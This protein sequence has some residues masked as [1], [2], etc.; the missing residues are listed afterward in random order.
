MVKR[1]Q[2]LKALQAERETDRAKTAELLAAQAQELEALRIERQAAAGAAVAERARL[3]AATERARLEAA[4]AVTAAEAARAERDALLYS[5][6]WRATRPLRRVGEAMSMPARRATRRVLRAAYWLA[7]LQFGRRMTEWRAARAGLPAPM[8]ATAEALPIAAVRLVDAEEIPQAD[9]DRWVREYDTLT[10]DDRAAIRAHI[11]RL[12]RKPLISVVM[13]AYETPEGCCAR[14]SPRYG[15]SSTRIGSCASSTTL[16]PRTP[17]RGYCGRP[18][19]RSL[20][21][22][23]GG[24]RA[25]ATSRPP[26]TRHSSW[27]GASSSPCLTTTTC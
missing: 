27:P 15:R 3:E 21:S 8:P 14:R 10:D 18:R 20:G 6:T 16:R 4:A 17:S 24:G 19:R 5:T 25:T 7:T 12:G 23:G 26:P 2:E 11:G 9:Y 22:S 13:P 1:M